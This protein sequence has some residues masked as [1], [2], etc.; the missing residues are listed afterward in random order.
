MAAIEQEEERVLSH[1]RSIAVEIL[2]LDPETVRGFAPELPLAEALHLDSVAQL[3][4]L[5][6]IEDKYGFLFQPEDAERLR[7]MADLV[8][9]IRERAVRSPGGSS[10]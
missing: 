10:S 7:T 5:T 9:I 6:E 3:I 8:Q 4:L 1:L 2:E